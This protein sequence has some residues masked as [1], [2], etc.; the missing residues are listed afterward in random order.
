MVILTGVISHARINPLAVENIP[1]ARLNWLRKKLG[2]F[3]NRNQPNALKPILLTRKGTEVAPEISNETIL[4]RL[5]TWSLLCK[6]SILA[7]K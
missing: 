1:G 2:K 7:A 6:I 5:G 4:N 3:K